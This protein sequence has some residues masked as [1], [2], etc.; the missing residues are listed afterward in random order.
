MWLL[1]LQCYVHLGMVLWYN[2]CADGGRVRHQGYRHDVVRA[3]PPSILTLL[4]AGSYGG[5]L[6]TYHTVA[7]PD[8]FAASFRL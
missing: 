4:E 3:L 6:A 5:M 7:K 8:V 1:Q 2:S